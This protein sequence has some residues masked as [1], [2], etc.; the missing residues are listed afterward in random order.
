MTFW[1]VS[2]SDDINN[3]TLVG[4]ESPVRAMRRV[5]DTKCISSRLR[6]QKVYRN[7]AGLSEHH[8]KYTYSG[9]SFSVYAVE[10]P[11]LFAPLNKTRFGATKG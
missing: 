9:V 2:F 11:V 7:E 8:C 4:S 5:L 1:T 6:D 3:T 10:T